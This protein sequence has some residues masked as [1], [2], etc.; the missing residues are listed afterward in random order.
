M[1]RRKRAPVI[2]YLSAVE[3]QH[4]AGGANA[5]QAPTP[6]AAARELLIRTFELP[7]TMR[8]MMA[9]LRE[10][11]WALVSLL[12]D[13][14]HELKAD[15]SEKHELAPSAQRASSNEVFMRLH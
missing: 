3:S 12:A 7:R 9:V 11:R 15:I 13:P 6:A 4:H 14:T 8:D 5:Q 1:R 10:Y 2:A